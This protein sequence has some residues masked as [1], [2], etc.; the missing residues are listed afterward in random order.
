MDADDRPEEERAPVLQVALTAAR[1]LL[2]AA[3]EEEAAEIVAQTVHELGGELEPPASHSPRQLPLD[4]TF[5]TSE[6][7]VPAGDPEALEVL[8]S[9]L[10]AVV[11]DAHVALGRIRRESHLA[12]TA[13]TDALTGLAD[14][15][16]GMR[17]LGRVD[18]GDAVAMVD[19]DRFKGV[20]DRLGHDAGDEVLRSFGAALRRVLRAADTAARF[21]GE[22]FVVLLPRTSPD[23]AVALL[24]RLREDWET[25]RPLPIT[26]SAGVAA[27]GRGGG[28]GALAAADRALYAAKRAGRDRVEVAP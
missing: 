26:F 11:E 28:Q 27:V 23:G 13:G 15:R 17:V 19:L 8:R 7:R 5:G 20:N 3:S 24:E 18:A 10:P 12:A 2:R 6:P 22:E 14:R 1:R 9:L 25:T 16:V 4:V 21:G